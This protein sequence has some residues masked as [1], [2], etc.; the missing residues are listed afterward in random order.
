[1]RAIF[2]VY[3]KAILGIIWM[4]IRP[5]MI[6]VPAIFIIGNVFNVSVAPLP[7]PLFILTGMAAW[8]LVRRCVQ[9]F[10]KSMTKNR[11]ILR[12]MYVPA[13]LLLLTSAAPAL[14]E[15]LV[16]LG[17][18][19]GLAGYYAITGV[20]VVGVGLHTLVTIPA[21][22]MCVLLALAI[23]CFTSI[24]NALVPDTWLTMRY[25]LGFWMVATPIVYPADIIPEQYRW[26]VYLNPLAPTVE[27]FRWGVLDYGTVRWEFVGLAVVETL[28]LLYLGLWFFGKQL[29]RLFDHM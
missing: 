28:V 17:L 23:G 4:I 27:L 10:T 22:L 5:L 6:A 1:M 25:T 15:F 29:N 11:A 12:R 9:W 13:L 21:V 8:V 20:Y 18:V 24:L 7:L 2:D 19:I 3:R 14:F 26:L 16:V